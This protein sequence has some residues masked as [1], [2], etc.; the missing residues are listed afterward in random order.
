MFLFTEETSAGLSNG[1]STNPDAKPIGA[2][3]AASFKRDERGV[4]GLAEVIDY[5]AVSTP[6]I[7]PKVTA[8]ALE[9]FSMR[10]ATFFKPA[11]L[12]DLKRLA[13]KNIP[14]S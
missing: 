1:D 10:G 5:N 3:R 8:R 13:G 12:T 11:L 9:D 4:P 14:A 6:S 7:I 2:K